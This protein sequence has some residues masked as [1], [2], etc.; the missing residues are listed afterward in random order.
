VTNDYDHT[1]A[2]CDISPERRS[3]LDS[4]R[5][6]RRLWLSWINSDEHHAIWTVLSEMVWNDVVFKQLSS[7]A[8][9]DEDNGL[10]NPL[11]GEALLNGHVATQVLDPQADG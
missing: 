9:G 1:A 11:L 4:Y 2:E 3:A 7:L 8:I 6:K 5:A 10:N